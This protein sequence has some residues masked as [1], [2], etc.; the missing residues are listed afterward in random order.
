MLST[1]PGARVAFVKRE[2]DRYGDETLQSQVAYEY[3]V[4]DANRILERMLALDIELHEIGMEA[5]DVAELQDVLRGAIAKWLEMSLEVLTAVEQSPKEC[6]Q[7]EKVE[8]L[9]RNVDR[10]KAMLTPDDEFFR[11]DK[12]SSLCDEAIEAHRSGLTEP[13]LDDEPLS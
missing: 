1:Q 8:E 4:E 3:L 2:V 9:K 12:L 7:V 13:L 5:A 10:T 11:S 6:G